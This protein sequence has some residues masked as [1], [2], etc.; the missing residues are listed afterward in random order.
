MTPEN[1]KQLRKKFKCSQEELSRILGV[2]T[3]TLS[4]WENGQ[5]TP[6]AKNLEQLEFLKQKL[7]K[8]D[9][10]NLKK[11]LLIAGVSFAAMA[12][13]GLMMSGLIDKNNIVERVKG[14]FNKK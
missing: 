4:R 7:G 1:I 12:P 2:T 8:E 10:A 11:I 6:S 13:V 14:L 5:A 3:A 9:P